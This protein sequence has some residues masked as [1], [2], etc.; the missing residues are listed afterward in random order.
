M[1]QHIVR[2]ALGLLILLVFL[3]H[4]ARFYQI[5]FITQ[6]DN[7]IYDARLRLT[8]PGGVDDR[9]VIL[10]ID[11]KSLA[12]P[13]LGRWPW[14]R[15]KISALIE[16]LFDKYGVL[17]IGFDVVWAEPD[18]SSGL[19]VL[20]G[21][22]KK[23][24]RD[25]PQFQSALK[26]L[27]P[28]L[29]RDALFARTIRGR[30]IVLGFYLNSDEDARESGAL[31][32]PVLPAGTFAGRPIGF[33]TWRGYGGNLPEL[34]SSAVAGGHFNPLIDFDG[35]ARRVPMLAEYKGK[36]YEPLS[37][38]MVRL[39]L[40]L[41]E[42]ARSK[43]Q[44]VVLPKVVPG[45]PQDGA[46][47]KGYGGLEW[48]EIGPLKIPVDEMVSALIPFRGKRNSFNYISLADVYFDKAPVEKL[49]GRIALIGTSAP[50]LFD[51][52]T[53]PVGSVYPGVEI[54]ANLIAGMLDRNIKQKPPFMVGAEVLL[55]VVGGIA[56]SILVPFLSPLRATL[57]CLI[58]L[59]LFT[60]L[61][62]F[63]WTGAG[64]VLPLASALL[65]ITALFALNM[66]YGYFIESR[67]KRQFTELFGQ[68]VPPE[69]V[70][71]MAENPEQYSM[72]G[73][74]EELTVL[75]SDIRGFT[76]I[77]ESLNPKE[78]SQFIN[79][80]LTSMSMVIRNNRGTLDKYIG[81]AI[82]AFWGAPVADREHARQGVLS[83]M[84]M[85]GEL[86]NVREQF[87]A[88]GWPDIRIGVG[89]NTGIMSVGDMGSKLRKAYTV[90]GDAVNLGSRLEGI[91]K[92]YGVGIICGQVTREKVT[93]VVWRELDRVRVKG[94]DEPIAIYEPLGF[95]GQVD[96]KTLD[97][98]KLWHQALK[99]YRAQDWDQS[100]LALYNLQRMDPEHHLY[101]V[102][103]ERVA[104]YRKEPPG[105]DW[106]G[107]WKF[108][109]K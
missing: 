84:L 95:E 78:L 10:D 56:L 103:A 50:G 17:I 70:D 92:Q 55:L 68:Y 38:A 23:E 89:V 21:L 109:T 64:S 24:L 87:A 32:E 85:Q 102:Y 100:E 80:Y 57:A 6:L 108:E 4:A 19:K 15:D 90:M 58:G 91:T 62:L 12:V 97:E 33:T 105:A 94:K 20:D 71:K 75:F 35:V 45:Y 31:P 106:D 25:V 13:Q 52:R 30:P 46:T 37:L 73:K 16:K 7:I 9:V 60:G 67:S 18:E 81:D 77:S 48:L 104:H 101:A 72:E 11:E 43:S 1:K 34:Q 59:L 69:L 63:M 5:G 79:E 8:M 54:H 47:A 83:A 41:D 74:S 22:A 99:A 88:R 40:G 98:L 66:S 28:Q 93:D 2:I 42:A 39:L 61:N 49:K 3:G 107:V 36:Y 26:E 29:D 27:R 51:L 14:G 53:T 65:M 96:K 44:S 86:K 76:T 82:M